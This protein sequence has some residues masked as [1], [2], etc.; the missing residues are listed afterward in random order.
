[1]ICRCNMLI[2]IISTKI[3]ILFVQLDLDLILYDEHIN[4]I[5]RTLIEREDKKLVI[6]DIDTSSEEEKRTLIAEK[7]ENI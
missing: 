6:V 1:M 2:Y 5:I 3:L 4:G 7:F